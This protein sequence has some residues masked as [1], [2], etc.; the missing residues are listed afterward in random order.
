MYIPYHTMVYISSYHSLSNLPPPAWIKPSFYSFHL[1][2][3]NNVSL[4]PLSCLIPSIHFFR[5][6]S[7]LSQR[8]NDRNH[9]SMNNSNMAKQSSGHQRTSQLLRDSY[10]SLSGSTLSSSSSSSSSLLPSTSMS[11]SLSL[12]GTSEA[13]L[14]SSA[15]YL[16]FVAKQKNGGKNGTIIFFLFLFFLTS[17]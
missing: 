7:Q 15:L 14:S 17:S 13:F 1:P 10:S 5:Q 16:A 3:W 9:T 8:M 12:P 11:S 4:A 6:H 2:S